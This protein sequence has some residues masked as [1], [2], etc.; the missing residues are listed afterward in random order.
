V[1]ATADEIRDAI[2]TDASALQVLDTRS[3]RENALGTIPG[4]VHVDWVKTLDP[5]GRF[6]PVDEIRSLYGA[7]GLDAGTPA[8]TFCASGFRAA[9]SYVL[10]KSLGY[11]SPKNYGP[12]WSEWSQRGDMPIE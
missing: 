1:I 10:L 5:Q 7:A 8:A 4:A 6:R 12:S 2:E 9:H 3:I 11:A